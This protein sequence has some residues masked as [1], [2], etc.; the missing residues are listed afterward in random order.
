M[1]TNQRNSAAD[2]ATFHT[3]NKTMALLQ[4]QSNK[5]L[6]SRNYPV[7]YPAKSCSIDNK[8]VMHI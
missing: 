7:N 6:I 4:K 3:T 5:K 1:K 8:V 2:G